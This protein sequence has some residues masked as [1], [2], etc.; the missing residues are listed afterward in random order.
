MIHR[1]TL[2]ATPQTVFLADNTGCKFID[3]NTGALRSELKIPTNV[4]ADGVWKW[5]A[6]KD[7]ILYGLVGPQEPIDEV[8]RGARNPAGWPWSGLGKQN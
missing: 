5:L 3:A 1:S 6:L 4:D 7:G 8:I 2:I